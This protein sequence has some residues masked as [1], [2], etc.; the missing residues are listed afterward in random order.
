MPIIVSLDEH[1]RL[2]VPSALRKRIGLRKGDAV[3]IEL[4]DEGEIR[5]RPLR[6]SLQAAKGLFRS[7]RRADESVV[8]A[9]LNERRTEAAR[10]D[11]QP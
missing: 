4:T 9:L 2:L 7:Q 8:E 3:S 10:E 6:N 5:I 1:A 11:S